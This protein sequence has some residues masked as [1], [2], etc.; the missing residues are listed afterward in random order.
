M[1]VTMVTNQ[2]K[3]QISMS[4]AQPGRALSDPKMER[5]QNVVRAMDA[6]T[7]VIRRL[8]RAPKEERLTSLASRRRIA[9]ASLAKVPRE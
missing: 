1:I 9:Q 6:T 3:L 2:S 7:I 4:H 8:L 5:K